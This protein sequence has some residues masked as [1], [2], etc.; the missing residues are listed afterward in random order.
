LAKS[1]EG[2]AK[3]IT[4]GEV[5][6]LLANYDAKMQNGVLNIDIDKFFDFLGDVLRKETVATIAL[7]VKTMK[8]TELNAELNGSCDKKLN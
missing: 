4:K 5:Y 3:M 2:I 1:I 8:R 6:D 7:A